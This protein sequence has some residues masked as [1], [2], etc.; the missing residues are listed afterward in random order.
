MQATVQALAQLPR[1]EEELRY[2]ANC[3][4]DT[5]RS[6]MQVCTHD[7]W[8]TH[9]MVHGLD[10]LMTALIMLCGTRALA[11]A[12]Q[13]ALTTRRGMKDTLARR[14]AGFAVVLACC[15]PHFLQC[16][17][18]TV[19]TLHTWTCHCVACL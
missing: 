11:L 1:S 10:L 15:F 12:L 8:Y 5:L 18:I 16:T 17:L 7:Y 13:E 6:N 3:I 2:V 9:T 4:A 14:C 19:P